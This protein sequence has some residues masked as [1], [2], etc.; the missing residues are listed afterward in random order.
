MNI[1]KKIQKFS[2]PT[3]RFV[4]LLISTYIFVVAFLIFFQTIVMNAYIHDSTLWDMEPKEGEIKKGVLVS[5]VYN[6]DNADAVLLNV[7]DII[8]EING[9]QVND[10]K[11]AQN[12]LNQY[13]DNDVLQYKIQ[14]GDET[15]TIPVKVKKYFNIPSIGFSLMG[16]IFLLVSTIVM[17]SKPREYLNQLFFIMG[18]T[19]C[20]TFILIGNVNAIFE[21]SKF[22]IYHSTV[23]QFI[24]FPL[25]IHFFLSF[26]IYYRTRYRKYLIPAIYL[27]FFL[28]ALLAFLYPHEAIFSIILVYYAIL[29]L[30]VGF[31]IFLISYFKI[32]D[33]LKRRPLQI[34]L[35]GFII[36]GFGFV[37]LNVIG[38]LLSVPFFLI[39]PLYYIPAILMVAIPL[40]FGYSIFRFK[41]MD[42]EFIVKRSLVFGLV[43]VSVVGM[44]LLLVYLLNNFFLNYFGNDRL[45]I[46]FTVIVIIAVTF[47]S[48]NNRIKGLVNNHLYKESYNYR[49]SLLE[50]TRQLP[51][52]SNMDQIISKLGKSLSEAMG[53]SNLYLW[54]NSENIDMLI[55]ENHTNGKTQF[56]DEVERNEVDEI[57][58]SIS[59]SNEEPVLLYD[60][61]LSE[62]GLKEETRQFFKKEGIVIS[63][64]ITLK[65]KLFG[66]L[67]FGSKSSGKVYSDE[68]IDLLKTIASQCSIAFENVRMQT[69]ELNKQKIEGE[70]QIAARIQHELLPKNLEYLRGLNIDAVNLPAERI[71]GDFYD[72]KKLDN[73]RVL[74]LVA[75]VSG[76][77]IP[78][79]LYISRIQ[80]MVHFAS[81]IF[82]DP[83]DIL[84]EIN[85]LLYKKTPGNFYLT[86]LLG[87]F[88]LKNKSLKICRAGH[89]QLI[90]IRNEKLLQL[91]DDSIGINMVPPDK[92][93][94][95]IV[96]HDLAFKQCDIFF[97]Y[98]NGLVAQ[99]NKDNKFFEL[100]DIKSILQRNAGDNPKTIN[101]ALISEVKSFRGEIEQ[102]DDI[103]LVTIKIK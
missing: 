103:T 73:D 44:Y 12:V 51:Y 2:E 62:L 90:Y 20:L 64:P 14:R 86:A 65:G 89:P 66:S 19:A 1:L 59:Y 99:C 88:D 94:K 67:N 34:I 52:M 83:K 82:T 11:Q 40:S 10:F 72:I 102:K 35:I 28:I 16:F 80:A 93:N 27:F 61:N 23:A 21:L 4:A 76:K 91:S 50:F 8:L 57:F 9:V 31:V 95:S 39:N 6:I 55:K 68:D 25:Y 36:G 42:S 53:I 47:D 3:L 45:L 100:S 15:L 78:A 38:L 85:R 71:A 98:T 26:P 69:E 81:R 56:V 7:G 48:V 32:T 24:F 74:V 29:S 96:S 63:V 13:K 70:I 60:I 22:F 43:T 33:P 37:Y 84:C 75:D 77:G 5:K 58:R 87:I 46:T 30:I 54:L 18:C 79:A 49:K 101:N 17:Y 41:I 97:F 92:F